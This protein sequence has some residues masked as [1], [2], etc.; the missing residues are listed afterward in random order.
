MGY[1]VSD[2]E[3]GPNLLSYQINGIRLFENLLA[4]SDEAHR[5]MDEY[6]GLKKIVIQ[7]NTLYDFYEEITS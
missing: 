6:D 3:F 5:L 4:A 1:Y 2:G 7:S